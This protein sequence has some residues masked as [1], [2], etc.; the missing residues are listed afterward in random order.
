VVDAA[1]VKSV[2]REAWPATPVER[3]MG[4]IAF[5]VSPET[6]AAELLDRL[7]ERASLVPVVDNGQLVGGVDAARLLQFAQFHAELQHAQ[8]RARTNPATAA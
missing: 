7:G 2:P 3:I 6:D 5:S 4:P 8:S 1:A